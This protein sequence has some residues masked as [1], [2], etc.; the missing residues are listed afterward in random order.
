MASGNNVRNPPI[1]DKNSSYENWEKAL[2]LWC[3]VTDVPAGKRGPVV[4]LSLS[5]EDR[6]AALEISL[7]E[8]NS[9]DGVEKIKAKLGAIYKKDSV[10]TAYETFE[11]FIYYKREALMGITEF[12]NEFERRYNKSKQ[13][14]F[15]LSSSTLAFFMLN[16]A[17]LSDDHKKLVKATIT[18]LDLVEMK[19]KL[20]KVFG[21]DG[22]SVVETDLKIKLEDI[23]IAEEEDE[24]GVLYGN[25]YGRNNR[26]TF[27][28]QRGGYASRGSYSGRYDQ[29]R[30]SFQ[31]NKPGMPK[32][33][34][35]TINGF[36]KRGNRIKC[37]ICE[38]IFHY[39]GACPE[40]IYFSVEEEKDEHHDIVLYQSNLLTDEEYNVFVAEAS[41]AA[42]LDSGA[43]ASVTGKIWFESY[44]EGLPIH[45]QEVV[46]YLDSSASFK[47]GSEQK[48]KS[49]FKA[50]IPA[51]IGSKEIFIV[52][53]VV[54]T[55]IPL[56]L[57]KEAMKNAGTN[58]NFKDDTV[59]MLGEKQQVIVTQ[60]G[61]YAIPLNSS[62]SVLQSVESQTEV[63]VTLTAE[64][65]GDKTKIAKKLHAQ[66][67]HPASHKLHKLLE[68]AGK[69]DDKELKQELN[70]VSANCEICRDY[71]KPSPKPVVGFPHAS[72][73]NETVAM[74]L[75]FFEGHIILHL[76]DHLTRFSSAVIIKSKEADQI[77]AGIFK[78]W[79]QVFGAPAKFLTDNGGEF[80]NEK[81]L[82]LAESMNIRVLTTAAQS[83]WSNG[84]VERHNATL[85]E[86]LQKVNA[87]RKVDIEAALSWAVHAKNALTNVHGFSPA[88]L[89]I[90]YTPQMPNV[91]EDKLPALESPSGEDI[92]TRNLKCMRE[93]R[94]AFIESET[95]ERIKRA[96]VH[97]VRPSSNNKFVT[98]DVVYY[99]RNDCKKWRGPGKVIG[100]DSSNIL[101]KHGANYV[102]VHACRVLPDRTESRSGRIIPADESEESPDATIGGQEQAGR[103]RVQ[104]TPSETNDDLLQPE[105]ANYQMD[106]LEADT[107]QMDNPREVVPSV[108]ETQLLSNSAVGQEP[109]LLKKGALVK[110]KM[111]DGDWKTVKIVR[112]TGKA[113]GK[114]KNFW[115]VENEDNGSLVEIDMAN[116]VEDWKQVVN[117]VENE[118]FVTEEAAKTQIDQ[119]VKSAKEAEI[120]KWL[121]EHVYTEV[122]DEG[123]D[124]L[125]TTW[126]VTNKGDNITK[127]RLV[128]RGYEEQ[129]SEIRSDSPTCSKDNIRLALGIAAGNEWVVHSLDVKAAF[130]QGKAIE[131]EVYVKPPKEFRKDSVLWRL[132]K[133]VYGLCDASRNWYL[134]VAEVLNCLGMKTSTVDKA[135]FMYN[136]TELEGLILVHVDDLLYAGTEDFLKNVILPFE[137]KFQISKQESKAFKYVGIDVVQSGKEISISQKHYLESM[138]SELITKEQH[139]DKLRYADEVEKKVFKQ[140]VGQ[141]GWIA[142]ISRPDASYT[143]CVL[144]T[145]QSKP[146]ISD[147]IL[148]R[149]TVK[150]LKSTDYKILVR[151]LDMKSLEIS[152][153]SDASFGNLECGAS[154]LGYII[155]LNDGAHNS[156]PI[157]WTSKKSKR[158]ARSTLTAET[159][160]AVDAVDAAMVV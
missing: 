24:E 132:N 13:H 160:A 121:E 111:K 82:K 51:E 137:E 14:G 113:T 120:R 30:E 23:N 130:L 65:L 1:L 59:T 155:F 156:V 95:S 3:L 119:A 127:A 6:D 77:I 62:R 133:V 126:V 63:S 149:K 122:R 52:T 75:K 138:K 157:S 84:L 148:Y 104:D 93:A 145:L 72:N 87:E 26:G 159:L 97:N 34:K 21:A 96:L 49:L 68:R 41:V 8:L 103:G 142:G 27:R 32:S 2:D 42:I 94:K 18:K 136:T 56:L 17:G 112:R 11:K 152:I 73:F 66:F 29:K 76:I 134:K 12:I 25:Y 36:D 47:F 53:D 46:E 48:F 102:R 88:Q 44:L 86:I 144:S 10:D 92:I 90:G 151:K 74:D 58:I 15:E 16:Q 4:A 117:E 154:Q 89:A 64:R 106:S 124:R 83:P 7:T 158:V 61:H 31:Q 22:A 54:A 69:G 135:V 139:V 71:T 118:I 128:I 125:S 143:Y 79:I 57:S 91:L 67:G 115:E 38:S 80:A 9:D 140:G 5:G 110:L 20:K 129:D 116:D 78:C 70:K 85:G 147:F 45:K 81:F 37:S 33:T 141:L 107:V 150:D 55:N 105:N 108:A 43:S 35:S 39:T 40:K 109:G 98:G 114:Y 146:Q 131:R 101:I 123:Q 60:S 19:S 28:K 100:H 153:F 99:K 50:K